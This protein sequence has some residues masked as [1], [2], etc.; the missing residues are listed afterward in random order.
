M[1]KLHVHRYNSLPIF[2]RFDYEMKVEQGI[3][4]NYLVEDRKIYVISHRD[5]QENY[6]LKHAKEQ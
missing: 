6:S 3:L 2:D 1:K 4:R 5:K